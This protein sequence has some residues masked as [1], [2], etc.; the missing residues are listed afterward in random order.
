MPLFTIIISTAIYALND[1]SFSLRT[2]YLS[3]LGGGPKGAGLVFNIGMVLSGLVMI[4]FFLNFSAYLRRKNTHRLL[5]FV[6]FISG[7]T[8]SLG[9]VFLGVFPYVVTQ[10]LHNFSAAF[11]FLGGLSFSIFYGLSEWTTQGISKLQASSGFISAAFFIIFIFFTSINFFN[12]YLFIEEAHLTEWIL[13][14]VV[15]IWVVEHEV[16]MTR[17]KIKISKES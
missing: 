2:H 11:F 1:P 14:F 10:E 12:Y 15:M 5:I 3:H 7:V 13:F 6:S 9:S 16:S 17:D 8:S 4:F